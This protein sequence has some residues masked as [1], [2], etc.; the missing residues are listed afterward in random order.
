MLYGL[1]NGC[2][3]T[4]KTDLNN[5]M[6]FGSDI[7]P[8]TKYKTVGIIKNYHVGKQHIQDTSVKEEFAFTHTTSNTKTRKTNKK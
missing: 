6:T 1:Y 7:Y 4:T 8:I 5:K 2:L 3:K